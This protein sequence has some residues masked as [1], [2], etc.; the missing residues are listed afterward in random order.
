MDV[1]PILDFLKTKFFWIPVSVVILIYILFEVLLYKQIASPEV[2]ARASAILA[3]LGSLLAWVFAN[4]QFGA[5]SRE[6][7]DKKNFEKF[8]ELFPQNGPAYLFENHWFEKPYPTKIFEIYDKLTFFYNQP[9][10][11]FSN[12]DLQKEFDDLLLVLE[13]T[14]SKLSGYTS[15]V[16]S[17]YSGFP[18]ELQ[19][20]DRQLYE[21]RSRELNEL[22]KEAGS[23]YRKFVDK[24]SLFFLIN[25]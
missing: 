19:M 16:G 17:D 20:S 2:F 6:D 18:V 8:I 11:K 24:W 7:F 23:L 5:K 4:T 9:G 25:H 22:T 1:Q 15:P 13:K 14:I 10:K 21:S 12:Q 3:I